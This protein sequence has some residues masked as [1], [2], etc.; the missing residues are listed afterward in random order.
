MK[1]VINTAKDKMGKCVAAVETEYASIRA[2]RANPAVLDKV[3]VDYYGVPTQINAM[4]AVAVSEARVLVITPWDASTLKSI[5]KAI[6]ASDIGITPTND[7]KAI[8]ITFP[9]LTEERRKEL[10]KQVKKIA[11]EG[12]VAVRNVRRD[13]MEK[14]KAMKKNSEI[15]EDDLKNCEKDVQKLTDKYC[16]EMDAACSAKEKEIMTVKLPVIKLA[17]LNKDALTCVPLHVGFIMDGNGRWAKKRGLPRKAGHSQGA[18]VF[19]RTVEDCRDIGIKYCTFYAFSTENWKRPKDEVD[20]IMKLLVKYLDDIRSM[21]QKNTRIIFLGDKSA[22]DDDIQ[23]RLVEIEE[24]S[25]NNDGLYVLV[26]LNYGG[27]DEIL[28][29]AKRLARDY[30][31]GKVD[32]DGFTEDDFDNYLYTKGIPPVDLIIRPSG[33]QR[34]SN[35]LIWQGAYAELLFMDVLWPDFSKKDLIAACDE[36]ARRNRRFGGL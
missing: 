2:G 28:T 35:F 32:L 3:T 17:D 20:A 1:D 21:A 4:A 12:K 15:T 36:Y 16:D 14:F 13:A 23:A 5:E 10:C 8:R 18:K 34:T 19:R 22:F 9:Q 33:E 29:A 27:K 11:E 25:K 30:K 7:G 31:E 26:A 6:L 24:I